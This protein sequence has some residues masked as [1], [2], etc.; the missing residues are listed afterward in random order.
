MHVRG[1][2]GLRVAGVT[3]L[4][5]GGVA[6]CGGS[7]RGGETSSGGQQ[8]TG[9]P[10][11]VVAAAAKHVTQAETDLTTWPG[12]N[13]GPKP[14]SGHKNLVFISC[15]QQ[16]AGCAETARGVTE[17][18]K[19][20]GWTVHVVDGK[21]DPSVWNSGIVNA[22]A[23]KADGILMVGVPD[24]AI[25]PAI[26]KAKAANIPIVSISQPPAKTPGIYSYPGTDLREHG[27][28]IADWI[29][30]DSK[31][32]AQVISL[33]NKE[34]IGLGI[35][36]QAF[37]TEIAKC[38]GCKVVKNVEYSLATMANQ[39]PQAVASALQSNPGAT[40]LNANLDTPGVF[41]LQGITQAGKKGKVKVVGFAGDPDAL[42]HIRAGDDFKATS[43]QPLNLLAWEGVNQIVRAMGGA[44][45][46][47]FKVRTHLITSANPPDGHFWNPGVDYK[48]KYRQL[49]GVAG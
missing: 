4:V 31:G 14:P 15:T 9:Q 16:A 37:D 43:A 13:D 6:A 11:P 24:G 28:D 19:T 45:A 21:A 44:A 5:M 30:A 22:V 26:G 29:I 40:Y 36:G 20:L 2:R 35:I 34:D 49:W 27:R 33:V 38:S 47:T 18:A 1:L 10:N 41:A 12:F 3:L 39:L 7:D 32:K 42:D 8:A 23:S 48:A 25:G 17:A 46:K